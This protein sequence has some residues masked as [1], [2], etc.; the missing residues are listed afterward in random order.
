MR[1]VSPDELRR[2]V[3]PAQLPFS[4]TAEL[5][6]RDGTIGQPRALDALQFGLEIR[7][8]GFNIFVVGAPGSGR[9]TTVRDH[10][11]TLAAQRPTPDDWVIV[12][13]FGQ[14]DRPRALSLPAGRG[15]TLVRD[16]D[17]FV[18][19][20]EREMRR[21][22][23]SEKYQQDRAA[24]VEA[25]EKRE[26]EMR[27]GVEQFAA[28]RGFGLQ[29]IPNGIAVVPLVNG[30]PME[31]EVIEHLPAEQRNDLE[32]RS[33]EIHE[34]MQADARVMHTLEHEGME[35]L[36]DL[37]RAVAMAAIA[38][39]LQLLRE[40]YADVAAVA[41]HLDAM[42]LDLAEHVGD[43]RRRAQPQEAATGM[44]GLMSMVEREET[45]TRYRG[46]L[47]VDNGGAT[48][49]PIVVD[50]NPTYHNLVGRIE[51]RSRL[52][53]MVTDFLQVRAGSL[54][55]ANG[56]FLVLEAVDVLNQPFAW[57]GLKRALR[58]GE[59]SIE[60]LGEQLS[61]VPT[62]TLRPQPIP[63][64]VKVVIIA[65]PLV[66]LLLHLHDEDVRELFKVKVDFAPD[67]SWDD[68]HV[69][70]YAEAIGRWVEAH[71]LRHFDRGAVTRVVEHGARLREDQ[72][73]LS[74][75]MLEINDLVTEAS[76]WATRSGHDLVQAEDVD[77]AVHKKE[78]RS[79]LAEERLGEMVDNRTLTIET[80]GSRTAQLNGLT[81]VDLGDHSFGHPVRIT[82]TVAPGRGSVE[83]IERQ[84]ELSGPSH[85]KGVLILSGY[86]S[87]RYAQK[88]PL[89]LRATLTFEQSYDEVDGD[90]ASSAELYTLLSA[91]SGLP[92][93]Q[94][95][96]VT[97]SVDQRGDVQAVGGVTRKIEGFFRACV[98]R[99][100]T[101]EQGVMVPAI[102]VPNLMLAEEV[103]EAVRRGQFHVW[104]VESVDEGIELLTGRPAAEVH[105]LVEERL[106]GFVD[107]VRQVSAP[108]EN[109]AAPVPH[110]PAK[111]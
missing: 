29:F 57:E 59:V 11:R 74:T 88:A 67:M 28:E 64:D 94:S 91:L 73:K 13:D 86:L 34:Q 20:A 4:S 30:R 105:R 107:T 56:G 46:N 9:L 43:L 41:A 103:V 84:V 83:S 47:L 92:V 99:G 51:Y 33:H 80:A 104:A 85:S 96:A 7:S 90:S 26:Q 65:T 77:T 79:N 17:G 93:K 97:G 55:R 54:L 100:L 50:R 62:A 16:L 24:L 48:G 98:A 106:A 32:R 101:G 3:D 76:F 5:T 42:E 87:G 61:F 82:A 21:A 14:P 66:H 12:Q 22:F 10:L 2:R 111:A 49:A 31:P 53:S 63:I 58:S 52:G 110:I 75:R 35:K 8:A 37:D 38:A 15:R 40:R 78:Y 25:V 60:N 71:G 72:R 70:D 89:A 95:V 108:A 109:G 36:A 44:L 1:E 19:T 6:G 69:M 68:E 23:E 102:N 45:S 18:E 27:R 81:V 39:P